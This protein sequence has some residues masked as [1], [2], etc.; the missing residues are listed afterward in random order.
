MTRYEILMI[1]NI[2]SIKCVN[3]YLIIMAIKQKKK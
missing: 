2:I 3:V 1:I